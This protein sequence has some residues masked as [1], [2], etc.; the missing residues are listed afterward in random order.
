MVHLLSYANTVLLCCRFKAA[1]RVYELFLDDKRPTAIYSHEV[2]LDDKRP[3]AYIPV[4]CSC[5]TFMSCSLK[6]AA[7]AYRSWA[8]P[9][10]WAATAY[11]SWA[12]PGRWAATAY[13]SWAAHCNAKLLL[14]VHEVPGRWVP[15]SYLLAQ[16][17][18]FHNFVYIIT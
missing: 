17:I 18:H 4:S 15:P 6:C 8:A 2:L 1:Y 14:F 9:G 5:L 12:A 7:T 16:I 13:R 10:R 11:R 3:T